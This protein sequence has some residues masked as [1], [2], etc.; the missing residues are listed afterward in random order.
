MRDLKQIVMDSHGQVLNIIA[1][2]SMLITDTTH[3]MRHLT[4][5]LLITKQ[6]FFYTRMILYRLLVGYIVFPTVYMFQFWQ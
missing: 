4:I 2:W 1:Q 3:H 6:I 5:V